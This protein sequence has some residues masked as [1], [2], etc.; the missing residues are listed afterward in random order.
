MKWR[1]GSGGLIS[2]PAKLY[3]AGGVP[4]NKQAA[5]GLGKYEEVV[6][7]EVP[8]PTSKREMKLLLK[9]QRQVFWDVLN[10]KPLD[11]FMSVRSLKGSSGLY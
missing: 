3:L 11:D 7:S 9:K 4:V 2:N 1:N 10:E 6:A 8:K 5:M